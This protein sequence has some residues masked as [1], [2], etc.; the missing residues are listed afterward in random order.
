MAH[1]GNCFVQANI[2][3]CD[4][5]K[6]P[7]PFWSDVAAS[8]MIPPEKLTDRLREVRKRGQTIVSLNGS[9]DILHAGHLQIIFE[10][11]LCGDCLV[12]ALN[13]DHSIQGYKGRD[14]PIVPL[15]YRLELMAALRWVDFVTWFDELDPREILK[16]IS[17]NVHVNGLEYGE[18]CIE[19][20]TVRA[21]GGRLHLV[22]RKPSL[23]TSEIIQKMKSC[24]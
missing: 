24:R 12:V 7:F 6:D 11:S 8:K 16:K 10:A 2:D 5:M 23:S 15:Q 13:T 20:E 22:P 4:H 18:N 17:P 9:F 14:R 21:L 1:C 19:A 3:M